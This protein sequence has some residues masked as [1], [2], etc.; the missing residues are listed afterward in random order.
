MQDSILSVSEFVEL[1]NQTLEF[2]YPSVNIEGEISGYRGPN[3]SGHHYFTLKDNNANVECVAFAG[4]VQVSLE[5]GMKVI[6][7]GRPN[8]HPQYK[9]KFIV[10]EAKPSGD[11]AIKRAFEL[12]KLK[13]EAEGLFSI[14]RKREIPKFPKR[15]GV[16]SSSQAAGFEDFIKILNS[17]WGG[18]DVGLADVQVQGERSPAQIIKAIEYFDQTQS[19]FDVLV[20][21]RGGGSL[22]DLQAFSNEAVV[23]AVAAS[24]TPTIVAVGHEVDIS[25]ADL[26]ADL[27]ASTPTDAARLVV[28][29]REEF[30]YQ[31]GVY[32]RTLASTFQQAILSYQHKLGG[33]VSSM[34]ESLSTPRQKIDQLKTQLS[35]RVSQ[36]T[37]RLDE[38]LISS[39]K[40]LRSYNP[41]RV[42]ARGYSLVRDESGILL[43]SVTKI[44]LT[45]KLMLELSDGQV[46]TEVVD[47]KKHE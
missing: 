18:V 34:S 7:K 20:I 3:R 19:P 26:A 15:I 33:L 37:T 2:A 5:D 4:R 31:I 25:L 14:D 17:R 10:N 24:R 8:H 16:I 45:Q 9:F 38:S 42:L 46:D 40:I 28:P 39:R 44:K 6:V 22:E 41:K 32:R 27:R 43:S 23:R 11:G 21:T 30:I 47:V 13:L 36:L 12:L 29:D 35:D 1:L